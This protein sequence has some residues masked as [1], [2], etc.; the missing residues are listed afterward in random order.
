MT[1]LLK[2][3]LIPLTWANYCAIP[4]TDQLVL[5]ERGDRL[6]KAMLFLMNWKNNNAKKHL[7]LVYSQES[8]TTY[9]STIEGMTRYLSTQYPNKNSANQCNGKKGDIQVKKGDDLKCEDTDSKTGGTAG[10]NVEDTALPK[11][12]T[13]PS[14]GASLGAHVLEANELLS[15][16]SR[17]VEEILGAHFMGIDDVLGGK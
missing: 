4:P 2:R 7:R 1:A 10:A 9:S 14:R 13:A 16:P 5:E 6:N 17:T 15:C 8:M 11:K 3:E 12:S